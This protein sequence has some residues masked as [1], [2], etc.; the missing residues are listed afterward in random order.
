MQTGKF[1]QYVRWGI[2]IFFVITASLLFYFMLFHMDLL[3]NAVRKIIRVFLPLIYG[4]VLAYIL[5]PAAKLFEHLLERFLQKCHIRQF[6]RRKQAVRL[7]SVL[8][9]I[10]LTL[11]AFYGLLA[12]VIPELINSVRNIIENFPGYLDNIRAWSSGLLKNYPEAESSLD[13]FLATYSETIG[14]RLTQDIIPEINSLIM[15]F[16]MG[17]LGI[18]GFLKNAVLGIIISVYILCSRESLAGNAKKALY[19]LLKMETASQ[20]IK[21]IQY[22]NRTFGGYLIGMIL[23][24]INIGMM[25]YLGALFLNIPYALLVSVI[26]AVT[27]AI[28]FFGP[29][30][31]GVLSILLIFLFSPVQALYFAVFLLILQQIDGNFI[32]PKILGGTTGLTSFMVLTAIIIGGGFF[33]IPGMLAGVPVCAVLCTILKNFIEGR[34]AEKS[35]PMQREYYIGIDHL[36]PVTHKAVCEVKDEILPQE[37]FRYHLKKKQ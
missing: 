33:G 17:V 8:I 13:S 24:C 23:D 5:C 18:L 28:P 12:L 6:K 22:I 36:D 4:A 31:G 9:T 20:T 1:K 21:N 16:S 27:N 25:C 34:L 37:V 15:E 29:Y 30:L 19:S 3:K 10:F 26:V 11:F 14:Q 32:A 35:L 2:T 7:I